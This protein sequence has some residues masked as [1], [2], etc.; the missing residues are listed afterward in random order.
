M[1]AVLPIDSP[2]NEQQKSNIAQQNRRGLAT[3]ENLD[4][5]GRKDNKKYIKKLCTFMFIN[6]RGLAT[7][8]NPNAVGKISRSCP[9]EKEFQ[10]SN[11]KQHFDKSQLYSCFYRL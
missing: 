2:E 4:V 10:N 3:L 11:R 6:R 7:L 1:V 8:E 5:V 9:S